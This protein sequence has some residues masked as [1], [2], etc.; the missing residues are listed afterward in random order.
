MP[1]GEMKNLMILI[2]L[3]FSLSQLALATPQEPDMLIYNNIVY[4]IHSCPLESYYINEKDRPIFRQAPNMLSNTGNTRGYVAHW[5]IE[6]DTLYLRGVQTWVCNNQDKCERADL[7]KLFG[8]KFVKGKVE[9]AWYSGELRLS[10][11]YGSEYERDIILTVESGKIV[12][13]KQ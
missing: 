5:E 7:K 13:K 11:G 10:D 9:A 1:G 8:N 12:K 3:L 4:V 6:S 2:P